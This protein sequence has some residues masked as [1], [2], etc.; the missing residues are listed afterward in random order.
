MSGWRPWQRGERGGLCPSP[1]FAPLPA[2]PGGARLRALLR[3]R[4]ISPEEL[5]A[6]VGVGA[7][8]VM[9]WCT[10]RR[11]PTP[12][13]LERVAA[14]LGVTVVDIGLVPWVRPAPKAKG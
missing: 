8:T 12:E 13:M 14:A 10:G 2:A 3:S 5:A 7:S 6:L 4:G 1:R 11:C 9:R